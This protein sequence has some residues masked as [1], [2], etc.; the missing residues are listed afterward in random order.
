MKPG[1]ILVNTRARRLI[2]EAA[3]TEAVLSRRI[4]AALDVFYQ[5]PLPADHPFTR[6][7]NV[8]LTPHLG[9]S[10]RR[11]VSPSTTRKASRT[12]SRSW[13]AS[14]YAYC[15]MSAKGRSRARI[16]PKRAARRVVQE[17]EAA[18]E[19]EWPRRERRVVQ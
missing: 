3:L 7:P 15:A 11:G 8:V 9:Y 16:A 10:V 17:C 18:P 1:A 5:E 4:V 2:D 6:A 19:R 12:R 13:T 14:P